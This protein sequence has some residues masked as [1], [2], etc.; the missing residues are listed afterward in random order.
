[1][2]SLFNQVKQNT[3]DLVIVSNNINLDTSETL[4]KY[5]KLMNRVNIK[6]I[7]FGYINHTSKLKDTGSY[8]IIINSQTTSGPSAIYTISRSDRLLHGNVNKLTFSEGINGD[9]VELVWNPCELPLIKY[10]YKSLYKSEET[11]SQKLTFLIK[12]I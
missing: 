8:I 11:K 4:N 12:I 1:M 6:S 7:N 10:Y 9:V 3:D 2:Y 5:L